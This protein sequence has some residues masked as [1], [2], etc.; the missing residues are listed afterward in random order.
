[1][2][3][4]AF[5][6]ARLEHAEGLRGGGSPSSVLAGPLSHITEVRQTQDFE[7]IVTLVIGLDATI[8]FTVSDR[9]DADNGRIAVSFHE[10]GEAR[11][12]RC[13]IPED[14]VEVLAPA[15][16]YTELNEDVRCH[17]FAS[18]PFE[19]LRNTDALVPVDLV[20]STSTSIAG[21]QNGPVETTPVTT[22]D[23]HVGNCIEGE[24][25]QGGLMAVGSRF[26]ICAVGWG[27][28]RYLLVR[29]NGYSGAQFETNKAGVQ[30]IV[31]SA[32]YLP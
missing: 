13:A 30:A 28:G 6:V 19:I 7:G 26:L 31:A 2:E 27:D 22:A 11:A 8:P 29:T 12:V 17:Y 1:M 10:T 24:N 18:E 16:W 3:G 32:R 5:L 14:H 9:S 4:R 15:G 20:V 23:N 21:M 25:R